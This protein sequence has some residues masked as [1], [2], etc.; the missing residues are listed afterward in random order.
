MAVI[1]TQ[2]GHYRIHREIGRGGMGVVHLAR[3]T[4]LQRDVAIK[5]LPE[6]LASNE[7]RLSRFEREARLLASLNHANIAAIYGLEEVDGV[8][9]LRARDMCRAE[10]V[11]RLGRRTVGRVRFQP[12]RGKT[13]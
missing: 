1:P 4:L 5:M 8:R 10:R 6:D 7:D 9:Y 12:G 13:R 3:D 11:C 2:I